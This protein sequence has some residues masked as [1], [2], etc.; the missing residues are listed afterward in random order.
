[1][2]WANSAEQLRCSSSDCNAR[3]QAVAKASRNCSAR[4]KRRPQEEQVIVTNLKANKLKAKI[5]SKLVD[6][7]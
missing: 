1:M 7:A 2:S 5:C 3:R 6:A 4:L